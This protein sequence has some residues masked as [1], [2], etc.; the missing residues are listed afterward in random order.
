MV[1]QSAAM[2]VERSTSTSMRHW[3]IVLAVPAILAGNVAFGV[4]PVQGRAKGF[5][6]GQ[7]ATVSDL[8]FRW[9][10]TRQLLFEGINP[11]S[12]AAAVEGERGFYGRALTDREK[13]LDPENYRGFNYPLHVV[14]LLA[15]LAP[16][17][18][19][20]VRIL[21]TVG[22]AALLAWATAAWCVALGWPVTRRSRV[23]AC[24]A[25]LTS[26]PA[27]DLLSLQQ[28]T[29]LV[30]GLLVFAVLCLADNRRPAVAGVCVACATI[31]PQ[32]V[33]LP[34]AAAILWALARPRNRARFLAALCATLAVLVG[35]SLVLLPTWPVWFVSDLRGYASQVPAST[36]VGRLPAWPARAGVDA[37]VV[38]LT[39]SMPWIGGATRDGHERVLLDVFA[40]A[41]AATLV[42]S[43]ADH[44]YD[45]V[46]LVPALLSLGRLHASGAVPRLSAA[47]IFARL[48]VATLVL[49][50]GGGAVLG[51]LLRTGTTPVIPALARAIFFGYA[52]LPLVVWI[53]LA[54]AIGGSRSAAF[55]NRSSPPTE[56]PYST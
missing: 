21:A 10:G 39:L 42:V 16:L 31:K 5:R 30:F 48:V 43:V 4:T 17:P 23:I 49:V 56:I 33:A 7:G 46:L 9:L 35:A 47:G 6:L 27:L 2:I 18:F 11:Y 32:L 37:L 38:V 53:G 44:L 29:G 51:L 52:L 36:L 41:L 12:A 8:Y 3:V 1:L 55:S 34:L 20:A 22:L 50:L 54:L 13:R 28:L 24:A 40:L 45:R 26:L 15:P 25:V 14:V 19:P